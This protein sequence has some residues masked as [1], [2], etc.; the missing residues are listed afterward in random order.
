[1]NKGSPS[2]QGP[3]VKDRSFLDLKDVQKG[4]MWICGVPCPVDGRPDQQG[5]Q[6][7]NSWFVVLEA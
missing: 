1:M 2:C 7:V 6:F 3:M 5:P 4:V